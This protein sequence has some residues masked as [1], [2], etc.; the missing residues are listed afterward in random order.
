MTRSHSLDVFSGS[1]AALVQDYDLAGS[2]VRVLVQAT[3]SLG[4]DAGGLLVRNPR[5]RLELL[6]AT[7]H[8]AA[9]LETYQAISDEGP[10]EECVSRQES[11]ALGRAEVAAR[12]PGVGRLMASAGYNWVLATPLRWRG[13]ALGGLNL[14]WSLTP[15]EPDELIRDAQV[16]C[17]LLT[18]YIVNAEPVSPD[19]L[20]ARLG[21]ALEGRALIEQ[22]KGVL[23]E[24][25]GVDMG[26]AYRKL[27]DLSDELGQPLTEVARSLIDAAQEGDRGSD[28][29]VGGPNA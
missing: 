23:A 29:G 24:Q 4:A 11:V 16:I 18:L 13:T 3:D 12:W 22:A 5:G 9:E 7:S 17:D 15:E 28:R 2:L 19:S 10:C 21:T 14:F 26:E 27:L 6:S 8:E 1:S 25:Q 20:R